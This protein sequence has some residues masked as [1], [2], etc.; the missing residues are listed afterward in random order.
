MSNKQFVVCLFVCLFV[1]L[2]VVVFRSTEDG[3]TPA[4]H[5]EQLQAAAVGVA[6]DLCDGHIHLQHHY[7]DSVNRSHDE[8]QIVT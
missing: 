6:K 4:A 5:V 7:L 2:F 8:T 3:Y 1:Y